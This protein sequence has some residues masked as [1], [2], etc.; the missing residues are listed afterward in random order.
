MNCKSYT[1]QP[2]QYKEQLDVL[3]HFSVTKQF[4]SYDNDL[5][6]V[7]NIHLTPPDKNANFP[8]DLCERLSR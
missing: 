8:V 5:N 2:K 3:R 1:K 7:L 6:T 4:L